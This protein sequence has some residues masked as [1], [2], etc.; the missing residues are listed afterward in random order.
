MVQYLHFG[1]LEPQLIWWDDVEKWWRTS[2]KKEPNQILPRLF[3][4]QT[5]LFIVHSWRVYDD[6]RYNPSYF[7][8]ST[9]KYQFFAQA[10]VWKC[11]FQV[12]LDGPEDKPHS[13]TLLL[14]NQSMKYQ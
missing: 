9:T 14:N 3:I 4:L 10:T 6:V 1:I 7:S 5:Y 12:Y 8:E 2:A 11:I 13:W